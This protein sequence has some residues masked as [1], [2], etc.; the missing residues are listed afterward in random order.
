MTA[1]TA[2]PRDVQATRK[3]HTFR[4]RAEYCL[5]SSCR[6]PI[7][8]LPCKSAV[9]LDGIDDNLEASF[10]IWR[11][12]EDLSHSNELLRGICSCRWIREVR[13]FIEYCVILVLS[14]ENS[15][16]CYSTVRILSAASSSAGGESEHK[17]RL[18]KV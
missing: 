12:R 14:S 9:R 11:Y 16:W 5:L 1:M 4:S 17:Q 15:C 8:H 7:P 18:R 10:R 3:F 13:L 6:C 2:T